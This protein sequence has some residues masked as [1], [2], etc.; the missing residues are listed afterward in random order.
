VDL[1]I[2]ST[3][4]YSTGR[5]SPGRAADEAVR[6]KGFVNRGEADA[7]EN[8]S[9]A[10]RNLSERPV[11]EDQ[12]SSRP[13]PEQQQQLT[14]LRQRDREVK[15]HELA[16]KSV[17]GRYVTGGSFTYQTGPNGQRYAIGGEVTIDSSAGATPEESLRKAELIQRAALAPADPSPQDYRVASQAAMMAAQARSEIAAE[18]RDELQQRREAHRE[19]DAEA[20]ANENAVSPLGRRAIASFTAIGGSE[21]LLSNPDPID[22]II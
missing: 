11:P 14:E 7:G 21:S 18:R 17:G 3:T 22:E 19:Q 5:S 6:E 20:S 13:T 16:H 12:P 1:S 8:R 9:A 10:A 4:A 2:V 15:A